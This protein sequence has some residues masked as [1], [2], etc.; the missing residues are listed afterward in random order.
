[1][2][3]AASLTPSPESRVR[4][5]RRR[6]MALAALPLPLRAPEPCRRSRG[7]RC[8]GD[9]GELPLLSSAGCFCGPSLCPG[10]W[11]SPL[12]RRNAHFS[13]TPLFALHQVRT[14]EGV[15]LIIWSGRESAIMRWHAA[16]LFDDN[17]V[18]SFWWSN[19]EL[20]YAPHRAP[21]V[22]S[23]KYDCP[24]RLFVYNIAL[25]HSVW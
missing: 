5:R 3:E 15:D 8:L 1:M 19:S 4:T 7:R 16:V 9:A 12:A 22:L 10:E 17:A 13:L 2:R 21:A 6:P 24:L 11:C 14:D 25:Q 20:R 18:V 23:I